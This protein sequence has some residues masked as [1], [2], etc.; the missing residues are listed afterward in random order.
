MDTNVLNELNE[1]LSLLN[2]Q[3]WARP[4]LLIIWLS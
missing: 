3:V 1:L 2:V 4:E